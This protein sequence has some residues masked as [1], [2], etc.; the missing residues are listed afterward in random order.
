MIDENPP[1]RTQGPLFLRIPIA[2]LIVLSILS[3]GIYEAYWIYEHWAHIKRRDGLK[4]SPFWRATFCIFYFH[5]LLKTIHA[6]AEMRAVQVPSF[7]PGGLTAGWIAMIVVANVI[8]LVPG[9]FATFV[10]FLVPS[11]LF[12]VPVQKYV[13]S[14]T[15]KRDPAQPYHRWSFGNVLC[16]VLGLAI[17]GFTIAYFNL[18]L[19][20]SITELDSGV[21]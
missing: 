4:I 14:V 18:E 8:D 2:R 15:H 3:C 1:A 11:Y 9:A 16:L 12:L 6:D 17:W 5:S 20:T 10:T 19:P 7:S 21:Q 13:N